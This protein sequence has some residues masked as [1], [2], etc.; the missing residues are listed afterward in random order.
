MIITT[1]CVG[2]VVTVV[3][4]AWLDVQ[5]CKEMK[6]NEK[7]CKVCVR[8]VVTVI[9][10]RP[11]PI[12]LRFGNDGPCLRLSSICTFA[13]YLLLPKQ[14]LQSTKRPKMHWHEKCAKKWIWLSRLW[15]SSFLLGWRVIFKLRE[16]KEK[17]S[18]KVNNLKLFAIF[19]PLAC[20]LCK[21]IPKKFCAT[22]LRAA[23]HLGEQV[24]SGNVQVGRHQQQLVQQLVQ[25]GG[26]ETI[27]ALEFARC[28]ARPPCTCVD[29]LV[30]ETQCVSLGFVTHQTQIC[31]HMLGFVR[32]QT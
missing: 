29:K 18:W 8:A 3:T 12:H 15:R 7:N 1:K 19:W 5:N 32:Q 23:I 21:E 11:G 28:R 22:R 13:T 2:I 26:V 10:A 20:I 17:K 30:R 14:R 9:I 6:I 27:G 4:I 24:T 31:H 16:R 25:A